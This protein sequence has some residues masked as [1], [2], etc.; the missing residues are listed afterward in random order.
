ML[1]IFAR[2]AATSERL[3]M[4]IL[5]VVPGSTARGDASGMS[6][7]TLVLVLEEPLPIMRC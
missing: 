2:M 4:G 7:S 3:V 5:S 1:Y 6:G